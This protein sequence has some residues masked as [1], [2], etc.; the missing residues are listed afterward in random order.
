MIV[1]ASPNRITTEE[2]LNSEGYRAVEIVD[3]KSFE[4]VNNQRVRLSQRRA[5][6]PVLRLP[7][8]ITDEIYRFPEAVEGIVEDIPFNYIAALEQSAEYIYSLFNDGFKLTGYT[9]TSLAI[10]LTMEREEL[11]YRIIVYEDYL[12]VYAP[13]IGGGNG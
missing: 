13:E 3:G 4:V 10:H 8:K 6:T 12:K 9:A 1:G 2:Q 11:R 5:A 7:M